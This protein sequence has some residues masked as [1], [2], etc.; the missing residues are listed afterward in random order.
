MQANTA[1]IDEAWSRRDRK[2]DSDLIDCNMRNS[3]NAVRLVTNTKLMVLD[4]L[5]E[6]RSSI[7][8]ISWPCEITDRNFE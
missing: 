1:A 2:F 6:I 3:P 7:E 8:T 5:P 4:V